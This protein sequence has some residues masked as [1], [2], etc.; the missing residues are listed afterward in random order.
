M[1]LSKHLTQQVFDR[2]EHC[3]LQAEIHLSCALARP[4][5]LFNQRGKIA[6]SALLQRNTLKF[7]PKI[8]AQNEQHYLEHVVPH[9]VAH[10]IVWQ[11]YGK[12]APHGQHWQYI[13]T[14]IFNLPADRTHSYNTDNIG[15]KSFDYQCQCTVV[16]FS[17]RRHNQV[18]K[19]ARYLCRSCRSEL[20]A[21]PR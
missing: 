14:Q 17:T 9:E 10:L 2:V 15:I 16:K 7:H 1:P 19:G 13:M 6:G 11:R 18:L 8:L 5:I 20:I 4:T 12:V 21:L 3:Y